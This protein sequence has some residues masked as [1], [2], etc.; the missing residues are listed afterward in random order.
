MVNYHESGK[1]A[2]APFKLIY[3][4]HIQHNKKKKALFSKHFP[5]S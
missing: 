2:T 3:I 4:I 5:L 1:I